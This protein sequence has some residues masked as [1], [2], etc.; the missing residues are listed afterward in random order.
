VQNVIKECAR[1]VL[2]IKS[3]IYARIVLT[4]IEAE[5]LL[6]TEGVGLR[7]RSGTARGGGCLVRASPFAACVLKCVDRILSLKVK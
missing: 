5:P 7:R 4:I 1:S 3:K 2:V 6:R